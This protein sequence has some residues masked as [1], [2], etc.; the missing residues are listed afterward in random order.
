MIQYTIYIPLGF[1]YI[2]YISS[3]GG[4]ERHFVIVSAFVMNMILTALQ[5]GIIM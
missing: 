3:G 2:R 1:G 5:P 4:Q